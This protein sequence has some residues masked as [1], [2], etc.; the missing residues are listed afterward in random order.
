MKKGVLIFVL[1]SVLAS[2]I[3]Y[4]IYPVLARILPDNQYIDVTVS[5][6]LLTQMA[7]FLS[8]IVAI[9]VG[10]SKTH[11]RTEAQSK[12]ESLQSLLFKLFL[13]I[14]VAFLL[15]SP[16]V[17]R[18]VH[19]PLLFVIPIS[20]MLLVSIPIAIVSGYL[21]GR[22][23]MVKLGILTTTSAG[24]QFTVASLVALATNSGMLA[25]LSMA[26]AQILTILLAYRIFRDDQLPRIK[27]T[28][29]KSGSATGRLPVRR[30]AAYTLLASLAVMAL[31][32]VQIADLLIVQSVN[33]GDT[34]FYTDIYVISRVVFFAG[35]IFVW[36]FL[37]EISIE[38]HHLNR[39][40]ILRLAGY[41]LAISISAV[42]GLYLYGSQ[43]T[44]LLFGISYD[45]D[46]IR[47]IGILSVLYKFSFLLI[48]SVVLYFIV[49]W[50]FTAVWIAAGI[51]LA[52]TIFGLTIRGG[53]DTFTV[54]AA[55][56]IMAALV[57]MASI[58]SLLTR[59][60]RPKI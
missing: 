21:T 40:P 36:P 55:L 9:T 51:T 18:Y 25:M 46:M 27:E 6:S 59:P 14:T 22:A 58:T 53:T 38:H 5:L 1:L 30:L 42:T 57:A 37:S 11:E 12:I 60:I 19:V 48:T 3:N 10:L 15:V 43:I 44:Q 20:L 32:I 7:T 24:L 54:L 39:K 16:F 31:N 8:S 52:I 29:L 13:A 41:F 33:N 34:K 4:T 35:T 28:V 56:N 17:M 26:L 49:L 23:K 45:L 2:A 47:S 50:D